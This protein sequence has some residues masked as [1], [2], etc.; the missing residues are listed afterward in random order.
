[1]RRAP[2]VDRP[3]GVSGRVRVDDDSGEGT[4][5]MMR[6][7]QRG[8][9]EGGG[10]LSRGKERAWMWRSQRSSPCRKPCLI[11]PITYHWLGLASG[12]VSPA[13]LAKISCRGGTVVRELFFPRSEISSGKKLEAISASPEGEGRHGHPSW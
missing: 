11:Q 10:C 8:R 4:E 7:R 3:D 9:P 12:A 13:G 6:R 5:K 2:F 1:M